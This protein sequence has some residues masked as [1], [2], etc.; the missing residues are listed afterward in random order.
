MRK[1]H[2]I[3]LI[4]MG[5]GVAWTLAVLYHPSSQPVVEEYGFFRM[6]GNAIGYL[7]N[8]PIGYGIYLTARYFIDRRRKSSSSS[9]TSKRTSV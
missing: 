6:L 8:I 2:Y 5:I 1:S 9:S 4:V 7:I 3:F